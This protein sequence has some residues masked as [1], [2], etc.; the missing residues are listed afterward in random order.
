[1]NKILSFTMLGSNDFN[2]SSKFYD[3]IFEPLKIKKIITTEN[4]VGYGHANE[5]NEVKFY[6]CKPHNG[7]PATYGNGTMIA[8]LARSKDAVNQFYK[9]ALENGAVDEGS[10]GIRSDGNYYAYI[11]DFDGNKIAAKFISN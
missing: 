5:P 10:P 6:L 9:I 8:F 3:I 11:R 4:Y 7:K 2:K 1:M